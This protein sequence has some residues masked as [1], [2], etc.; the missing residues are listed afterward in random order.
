MVNHKKTECVESLARC[1]PARVRALNASTELATTTRSYILKQEN[2][3][4]VLNSNVRFKA[5]KSS[6]KPP[7][8]TDHP[9]NFEVIN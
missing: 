1:G 2:Y 3:G 9:L 6:T 7:E 8:G 5:S 4:D